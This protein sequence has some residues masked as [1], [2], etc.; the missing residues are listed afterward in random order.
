MP[1]LPL[2]LLTIVLA[3]L[4]GAIPTGY[5]LGKTIRKIDIREHGSKNIGATN[6]LRVLGKKLGAIALT[7]DIGKGL[8]A[9]LLIPQITPWPHAPL[10]CAIA[11]I[12][13]HTFSIFINFKGGKG[14]ATT[15][16]TFLALTPIPMIIAL[17]T[18]AITTAATR[19]VSLGSILGAIALILT[20]WT[21]PLLLPNAAP[22][23]LPTQTLGTL[24][25]LIVIIRHRENIKRIKEG[26]ENKL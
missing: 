15:C 24:M 16:G 2:T 26:T 17:T 12:L 9:V 3:Y 4:T 7:A 6:T 25:A 23:H 19:M 10:T 18:F 5:W 8:F 21:I 13:G 1:D 20:L 22:S 14:V 11:A